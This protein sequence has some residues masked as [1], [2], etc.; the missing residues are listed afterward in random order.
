[1][2]F[3]S[4]LTWVGQFGFSILFPLCFFL[5]LGVWLQ[6]QFGFGPWIVLAFGLVGLLTS[7]S[8]AKSCL[9]AILK[10][11]ERSGSGTPPPAAFN[12]HD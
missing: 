8:T 1:M 2:K 9:K 5:M 6:E 12:D 7:F 3:L 11:V 10:E 4:L